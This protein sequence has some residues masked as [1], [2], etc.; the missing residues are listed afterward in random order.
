M[1]TARIARSY[2]FVPA[3]RPDR[4]AKAQRAGAHG[5]I[6]DLEDAVAPAE[7]VSARAALAQHLDPVAPVLVRVNGPET[8]WFAGDLDVCAQPG[9]AGVLIPKAEDV[10]QLHVT[11]QRVGPDKALFPLIET[12]RGFERA[13]VLAQCGL[14]QRLTFGHIDF[15]LD[16]GI[17]GEQD[18]LLYFRSKLVLV[19]RL[20]GLPAPIDGVSVAI[21]DTERVRAETLYCR[22]LGFGGKLC[23]HPKQVPIVNACFLPSAEEQAWARRVLDAAAASKGSAVAVDGKMVDVP[24]IRKAEEILASSQPQ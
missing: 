2:L 8:E 3:H 6:V 13:R 12:G 16:L 14:A 21:E 19:S 15:Q 17:E 5:V 11:R 24:V 9:V 18:E 10:M 4:I 20:A 22:R 1:T 7:K 23:I